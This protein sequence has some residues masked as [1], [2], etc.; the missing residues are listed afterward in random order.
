MDYGYSISSTR[1]EKGNNAIMVFNIKPI[2]RIFHAFI[3]INN[4]SRSDLTRNAIGVWKL[5]N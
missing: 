4:W 5:K 3:T 1:P 2:N